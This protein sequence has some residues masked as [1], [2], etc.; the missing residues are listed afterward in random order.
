MAGAEPISADGSGDRARIGVLL[1]HGITATPQMVAPVADRLA[2]DGYAVRAPLLPGHGTHWRDMSRTRY[3]DWI[4]AVEASAE[5]LATRTDV[6]V[7]FGVSLGGAL[8]ADLAHGRPD[9]VDA[10]VLVNP[11][12]TATDWRLK[13][14]PVVKH[15][16]PALQGIA[17]DIRREGPPRELA[18]R[19]T[20]LKAF[21][22]F[23]EQWPRIAAGLPSLR[24]PVLLMRSRFDKVVPPVSAELFLREVGSADVTELWLEESAH[25][26]TLDHDAELVIASTEA[27]VSRVGRR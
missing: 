17:D 13:V 26:A 10:L 11:A 23:T 4:R 18:Y 6:L 15:V 24:V 27:F 2:A 14:I 9:L 1:V 20:P 22:S 12:F 7:A 19:L 3:L 8:V 16:V 5:E 21:D 25:V